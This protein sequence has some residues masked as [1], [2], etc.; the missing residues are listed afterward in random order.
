[1]LNSNLNIFLI[2][3]LLLVFAKCSPYSQC[4]KGDSDCTGCPTNS[5]IN[6]TSLFFLSE[7]FGFDNYQLKKINRTIDY[8]NSTKQLP[9]IIYFDPP[10]FFHS[11]F[12]YHCCHTEEEKKIMLKVYQKVEWESFYVN[13]THT[14]CNVDHTGDVIYIASIPDQKSQNKLFELAAL[15]QNA[16]EKAGIKINHP[17]V[18]E[19]HSTIARVKPTFTTNKCI[20]LLNS[21]PTWIQIK[22]QFFLVSDL[23]I[24]ASDF[25]KQH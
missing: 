20:D 18:Q 19:F 24:Q 10:F 25:P 3:F 12:L 22:I 17:R 5:S 16:I 14:H 6:F 15:F 11:S 21:Q 1:M 7:I 4:W 9:E 2:V 8:A 13:F 23:V